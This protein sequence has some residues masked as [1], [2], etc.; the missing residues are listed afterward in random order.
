M[1]A[2]ELKPYERQPGETEKAWR[3]FVAFRDA[4]PDREK[5][6]V[7]RQLYGRNAAAR[8]PGW[9]SKWAKDYRWDERAAAWDNEV[10]RHRRARLLE[11]ALERDALHVE[12][13]RYALRKA[14]LALAGTEDEVWSLK[15]IRETIALAISQERLIAG[16]V[17]DRT[18]VR[19]EGLMVM[20]GRELERDPDLA[21]R[22]LEAENN[23][24]MAEVLE[25][26][27]GPELAATLANTWEDEGEVDDGYSNR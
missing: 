2:E 24:E 19:D 18:E 5:L 12:T 9:F 25:D 3:A 27:V 22:M 20:V 13:L 26:I 7:Y 10:D 23:K 16:Q 14:L 6:A 11:D 1:P 15:D 4:G 17:T 8:C 21:R